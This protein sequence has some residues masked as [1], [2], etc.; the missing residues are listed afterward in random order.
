MYLE[1]T[2][3][4]KNVYNIPIVKKKKKDPRIRGLLCSCAV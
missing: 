4:I 1:R 2:E 3:D